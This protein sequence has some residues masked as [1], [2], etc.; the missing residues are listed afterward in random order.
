MDA[1]SDDELV[2]R[3]KA[4]LPYNVNAYRE[5]LR[6]HEPL[7][8][9]S[10]LKML[11][12]VQDAEEACQDSFLQVFHKISQFEGRSAFKTWLYR[13]VYNR[14]IETRRKDARRNQYHAKLKEEVE[15]E[16]LANSN[17]DSHNEITGRVHEVIAKMNGEERR[18]VTLRYISGLSIQEISDVLEIGLSA[19]KMRLYRAQ[20][21]FKE[22]YNDLD[23]E[24][25]VQ[26]G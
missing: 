17:T 7:V 6:R 22:I 8:Y 4:E 21:R 14:C 11:G 25:E 24:G 1:L 13:I 5:L 16:E 26:E 2:A 12:S 19:T 9:R 18:L 15:N 10:C 20:E 3:C 23:F